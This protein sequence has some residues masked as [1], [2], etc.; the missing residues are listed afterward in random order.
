MITEFAFSKLRIAEHIQCHDDLRKYI[1]TNNPKNLLIEKSYLR[2]ADKLVQ[3]ETG[4]KK[5]RKS[6]ITSLLMDKDAL[7]DDIFMGINFI[8]TGFAKHWDAPVREQ[9]RVLLNSIDNFGTDLIRKSYQ[10][11]TTDI[12]SLISQWEKS[13]EL[14]AILT[15]FNLITWKNQLK[16]VNKDFDDLYNKRS[17]EDGTADALPAMKLLRKETDGLWD[18][19]RTS[20]NGKLEDF[21]DDATKLAPYTKLVSGI[22][23]ILNK[24]ELLVASRKNGK[25]T[26]NDDNNAPATSKP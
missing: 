4:Y 2:Y 3:Y 20:I 6:N 24:Y 19:L 1:D 21:A 11:E 7:R 9:A 16:I 13:P 12:N 17:V 8:A 15:S 5:A 10:A 14:T 18:R 23:G 22:N 25:P 26:N